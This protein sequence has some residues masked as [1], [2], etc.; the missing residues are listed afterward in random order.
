MPLETQLHR[1]L[2]LGYRSREEW[3]SR[4]RGRIN[5]PTTERRQLL[6]RGGGLPLAELTTTRHG[7]VSSALHWRS[8]AAWS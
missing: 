5:V 4:V 3:L 7:I 8:V 1:Q 2:S 6:D